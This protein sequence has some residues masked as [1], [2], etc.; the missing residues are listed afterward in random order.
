MP[1]PEPGLPPTAPIPPRNSGKWMGWVVAATV[2]AVLALVG[3]LLVGCGSPG[4]SGLPGPSAAAPVPPPSPIGDPRTADPCSLLDVDS[5]QGFGQAKLLRDIGRPHECII[6]I[7]TGGGS[8]VGLAAVFGDAEDEAP[9]GVEER[10]GELE[11][12]R[13][14]AAAG[15]CVRTVV[16]GDRSLVYVRVETFDGAA[17]DPCAVADVGTRTAISAL[18]RGILPRRALPPIRRMR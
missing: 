11:I 2:V 10:V 5:V 1:A 4:T 6:A 9:A 15:G 12:I 18:S 8:S 3:G 14:A 17:A 16:L 7:K 13:E